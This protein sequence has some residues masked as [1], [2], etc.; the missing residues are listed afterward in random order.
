M[1]QVTAYDN[2][3]ADLK[4][5]IRTAQT[6]AALAVNSQLVLLYWGIGRDILDR[7][8]REG[9][10][11][12][13]VDQLAID[14]RHEF[15]EMKGFSRSNLMYMRAFA[16]AWT[17]FEF[18]QVVLGQLPWYHQIALLD[19]I[20]DATVREWYAKAAIEHGWSRNILVHQ[21]ETRVHER[22]GAAI[23][24][25]KQTLPAPQSEL[26]QH[27]IKDPLI[28]DFLSLGPEAKER[29]LENGLIEHLKQ[30]LLELGK[31]FAF[32]GRQYHLAVGGQDY[33]LDLLF[34]NT[35][36]HAYVVIDLK[37]DEFK[38]EYAGKMQ[39]YLAAVD[40]QLKSAR[41]DS[42]IGLILCKTKN[43]VIVE[44]ALRDSTKPIGVAEYKVLPK[45]LKDAMP[46]IEQLQD[47]FSENSAGSANEAKVESAVK[48]PEP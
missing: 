44:Y 48:R 31:G 36:L 33:Y 37:I 35:K 11:A 3:L 17:D 19:K 23:T 4:H 2:W 32:V 7:Q 30:F 20:A 46:S 39:F 41:D 6:R 34:Y 28:F 18:V 40:E 45:S 29:D 14:L 16:A 12:K 42:S 47:E 26:A 27:L 10:G 9:W 15:P 21:I 1:K 38:P 5:R 8:Q 25:F 13:I 22:H 43:G 24:N